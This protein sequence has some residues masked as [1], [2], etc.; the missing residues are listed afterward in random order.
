MVLNN[1]HFLKK[2]IPEPKE[3]T[4]GE[5]PELPPKPKTE[6]Y[7]LDLHFNNKETTDIL[8]KY[9]YDLPSVYKDDKNISEKI[10]DVNNVIKELKITSGIADIEE[11]EFGIKKAIPKAKNP[12]QETL[13]R[14][15]DFNILNKF[16]NRLNVINS[17][18]EIKGEG[19]KK[20]EITN[21]QD[22][23]LTKFKK[24]MNMEDY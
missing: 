23:T 11:D 15:R 8:D 24:I 2:K 13:K 14:I 1:Y 18:R 7:F 16:K 20:K 22:V 21:N 4:S 6:K 17:S 9:G 10:E 12:K 3:G 19:I 5:K